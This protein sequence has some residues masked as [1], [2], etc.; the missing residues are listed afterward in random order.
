MLIGASDAPRWSHGQFIGLR[1]DVASA[2]MLTG[3]W[4]LFAVG[5]WLYGQGGLA[6]ASGLASMFEKCQ[7]ILSRTCDKSTPAR[8]TSPVTSGELVWWRCRGEACL[9]L[10]DLNDSGGTK[11]YHS[12]SFAPD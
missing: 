2:I 6:F 1:D 5:V 12:A 8:N 9:P 11:C 4:V 10:C 3:G 7:E